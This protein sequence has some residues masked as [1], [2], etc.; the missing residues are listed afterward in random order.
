M[1][2]REYRKLKGGSQSLEDGQCLSMLVS[3]RLDF[4]N[5]VRGGT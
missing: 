3:V 4:L 1:V 2:E 5:A